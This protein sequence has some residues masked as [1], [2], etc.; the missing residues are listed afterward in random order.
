[1]KTHGSPVSILIYALFTTAII[2]MVSATGCNNSVVSPS[3]VKKNQARSE[4]E[5]V[6][7][8]DLKTT[9][10]AVV[11]LNLEDV[12][13]P[14]VDSIPDT[15]TIGED[16]FTIRYTDNAVRTFRMESNVAFS[17]RLVNAETGELVYSIAPNNN[18]V[19]VY[20]SA[21]DY[22]MYLTSWK[23]YTYDSAV[24]SQKIFIQPEGDNLHTFIGTGGC[25][26]CDLSS[27]D[28]RHMSFD[29]LNFS[30]ANLNKAILGQ[31]SLIGTNFYNANL[32][33]TYFFQSTMPYANLS[34]SSMKEV[35]LRSTDL[36]YAS[37]EGSDI[38][39]ADLR[40][41]DISFANFCGTTKTGVNTVGIIYNAQTQCWP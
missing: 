23:D 22:K 7:N 14:Q 29:G 34:Y 38:T 33:G 1:M 24:G 32:N 21:G 18:T 37:L 5:F 6:A 13:S 26:N 27:I 28:L 12:N 2:F 10:G 3:D 11:I 16:F 36:R 9:S 25:P 41:A 20:V 17:S 19:S 4:R 31:T 40:F 8:R 15:G 30:G 39:N 35:V